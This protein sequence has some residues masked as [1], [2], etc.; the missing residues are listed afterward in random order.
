MTNRQQSVSAAESVPKQQNL[1]DFFASIENEQTSMFPTPQQQQQPFP[2]QSQVYGNPTFSSPTYTQP[3]NQF[4]QTSNQQ[5]FPAPQQQQSYNTP[6]QQF[7]SPPQ[8]QFS[9]PPQQPIRPEW[10]GAGFGG[11][12][13]STAISSVHIMP[14]ISSS[15]PSSQ[16]QFSPPPPPVQNPGLQVDTG[17]TNPFRTSMLLTNSSSPT[18][19]TNPFAAVQQPRAQPMS[20]S[21]ALSSTSPFSS[22]TSYTQSPSTYSFPNQSSIPQQSTFQQ[23]AA[24]QSQQSTTTTTQ[25]VFQQSNQ[26][27]PMFNN[28][29]APVQVSSPT[30][31][32]PF[33][34]P[35]QHLSTSQPRLTPQVTGSNPFR[36][37][38]MQQQG[39]GGGSLPNGFGWSQQ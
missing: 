32:N 8:Q 17:T 15:A 12:T 18:G 25:P 5:F 2:S 37:S 34:R 36:Q 38:V 20:S 24:F 28:S 33:S 26:S 6:Q 27:Q 13:P 19:S 9:S 21:P 29:P 23:P 14:T 7:S 30:G 31:T 1:I 35:Q 4:P 39:G 3:P 22:Q 11:Y 16:T 10:T